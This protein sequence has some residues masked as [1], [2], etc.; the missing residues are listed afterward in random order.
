MLYDV[1]V[2]IDYTHPASDDEKVQ[3]EFGLEISITWSTQ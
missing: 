3:P 2:P 1:T